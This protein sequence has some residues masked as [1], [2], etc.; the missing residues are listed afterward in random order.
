MIFREHV[1]LPK[2]PRAYMPRLRECDTKEHASML[3]HEPA[4][5]NLPC[6]HIDLSLDSSL[7][8][9][10]PGILSIFDNCQIPD[11]GVA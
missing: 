9:V 2:A 3:A 1:S 4:F 10:T 6:A 7:L 11:S 5:T 8:C